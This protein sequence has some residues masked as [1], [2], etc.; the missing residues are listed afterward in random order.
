[1][2]PLTPAFWQFFLATLLANG[3]LLV[4]VFTSLALA[5]WLAPP[6]TGF[7]APDPEE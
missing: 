2:I 5:C 7:R 3:L 6:D 4:V 1:M